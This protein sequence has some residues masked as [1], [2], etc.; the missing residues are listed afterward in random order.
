MAKSTKPHFAID[1]AWKVVKE[2]CDWTTT[3]MAFAVRIPEQ[4]HG[5]FQGVRGVKVVLGLQALG[6][7][8]RDPRV[9]FLGFRV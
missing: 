5:K 4:D 3:E 8:H 2:C 1:D 6:L 7:G 9:G